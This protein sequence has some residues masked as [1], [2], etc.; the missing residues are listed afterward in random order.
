MHPAPSPEFYLGGGDKQ[1]FLGKRKFLLF[2]VSSFSFFRIQHFSFP[3][4]SGEWPICHP[5]SSRR[6]CL[7]LPGGSNFKHFLHFTFSSQR[8]ETCTRSTDLNKMPYGIVSLKLNKVV[9]SYYICLF[10]VQIVFLYFLIIGKT[11]RKSKIK[12]Q[13]QRESKPK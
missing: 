3:P 11:T 6:A 5:L 12:Q 13:R 1:N 4:G 2:F 7:M 8:W 9:T 10:V